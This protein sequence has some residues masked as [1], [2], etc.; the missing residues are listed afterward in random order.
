MWVNVVSVLRRCRCCSQF[1]AT[2]WQAAG[3]HS[4]PYTAV[5][6][7]PDNIG[8]CAGTPIILLISWKPFSLIYSCFPKSSC[9]HFDKQ[10][11]KGGVGV[12]TF[13]K[14]PTRC[15]LDT[16]ALLTAISSWSLATLSYSLCEVMGRGRV[17]VHGAELLSGCTEM[18]MLL[19][20]P[21]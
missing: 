5:G 10:R 3:A 14:P 16:T 18:H 15:L 1:T 12:L 13:S 17:A 19:L 11:K 2:V 4:L 9:C 20:Q 6:L 21:K 7:H 8:W